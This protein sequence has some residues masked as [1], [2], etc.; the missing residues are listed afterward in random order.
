MRL[1]DA[2]SADPRGKAFLIHPDGTEL[3]PYERGYNDAIISCYYQVE[4]A[5]AIDAEPVVHGRCNWCN[6]DYHTKIM[7]TAIR[8]H[9]NGNMDGY[10]LKVNF[11]PNCGAKMDGGEKDV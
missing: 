8:Y 7:A 3:T 1:I 6:G 10:E 5:P 11:C 2:R 9:S 4:N